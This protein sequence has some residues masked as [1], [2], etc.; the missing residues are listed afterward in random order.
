MRRILITN[1]DGIQ[2]PGLIRLVRTASALGKVSVI[3]PDGQRSAQSHSIT[4]R[5]P[6]D[7]W[8]VRL[9]I[10]GVSAYACSGTPA[11]CVRIGIAHLLKEKPDWVLSG[12]NSGYNMGTD[13]Q[14]SA[15]VGAAFEARITGVPAIAVSE[16]ASDNH[17]LTDAFLPGI[18]ADLVD[19]KLGAGEIFNV[20][21]P[22]GRQNDFRGILENRR[23]GRCPMYLAEYETVA[24]Q[25]DGGIRV[26]VRGI[27]DDKSV[28]QDEM[29]K[30]SDFRALMEGYI[31][32]G[33]V[34]NIQ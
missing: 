25:E 26:E 34:H 3:A 14:Y 21:F 7:L 2:S 13:I 12:I 30:E 23:V 9:P 22:A 15:T 20:N 5:K 4:L 19:R 33:T 8:P 11:D 16:A 6:I 31:S 24:L 17:G 18:L 28:L 29:E 32:I 10:D 27:L 1:D